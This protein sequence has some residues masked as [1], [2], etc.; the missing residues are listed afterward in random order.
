MSVSIKDVAKRAGVS[1]ATVS[2]VMNQSAGVKSSKVQ[3]VREALAYYDYQPSQFGRGLVTGN[4]R[5]IGVYSPLPQG[6]MFAE[7]YLL[8][9]LRGI[10]AVIRESQYSLLLIN[11]PLA[12]FEDPS[13]K[14][15][16]WAYAQQKKIDGLILLHVPQEERLKHAVENLLDQGFPAGYIGKRFH[17]GGV[18]VYAGYTAYMEDALEKLYKNGHR[19]ILFIDAPF[20]NEDAQVAHRIME[21]YPDCHIDIVTLE[22]NVGIDRIRKVMET[23]CVDAHCTAILCDNLQVW[24]MG[25]IGALGQLKLNVPGDVS[26]ISTEHVENQGAQMIPAVNCYYVPAMEMGRGIAQKLIDCLE[27]GQCGEPETLYTPV[28]Q[29]RETVKCLEK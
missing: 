25:M 19:K 16:F 17:N 10:D 4:S 14:P 26:I 11:E 23:Y 9:C 3:A 22:V 5:I 28:Y 20:R 2:R 21:R 18:N 8:E 29:I 24:V 1:T 7:G 6:N 27:Q 15:R 12:Y 13:A